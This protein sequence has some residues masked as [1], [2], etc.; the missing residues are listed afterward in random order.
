MLGTFPE[1]LPVKLR[2]AGWGLVAATLAVTG[3]H[4]MAPEAPVDDPVR[5]VADGDLGRWSVLKTADDTWTV[6]WRSPSRLP[7]TG[8][9]PRIVAG[10]EPVGTPAEDT[11]PRTVV[12]VVYAETAPDPAALDVVLSGDRLDEPGSDL[13]RRAVGAGE[14]APRPAAEAAP[15]DPGVP[16]N[17]PITTS[18]YTLPG[19]QLGGMPEKVEMVGHV[20]KPAASAAS[21]DHPL[22]LFLHG[23]HEFCYQPKGGATEGGGGDGWPCENGL[24]PIPSQL[25]YDYAQRLLASQGYVTVSIAANGINAQDYRLADGGAQ[26]RATLVRRHLDQWAKWAGSTHKVDLSKVILVGH[27]RGGEGVARAAL[28]IP[29]SA[30]YRIAGQVLLAPTDFSRQTSPYVPTATVLPYCDGD[31]SDLQGQFFTDRARDLDSR[32]TSLKSSVMV[33]GANHNFFNT[34]WTPGISAAPSFDDW[35]GPPTARCGRKHP[36]RLSAAEQRAVGKSYIAGA[37]RLMTK[38]DESVLPLYDGSPVRVPSAG[39][40]DVRTHAIG[41]GRRLVRPGGSVGLTEPVSADTGI[42]SGVADFPGSL[43]ICGRL[44]SFG[45][46][47]WPFRVEGVPAQNAFEMSWKRSGARGGLA[48]TN[49]LDLSAS[50]QLDLRTVVDP[51]FGNVR[52]RVRLHDTAGKTALVTPASG[53]VVPAMPRDDGLIPKLWAQTVRVDTAGVTGIDLAHIDRIELVGDSTDGRIWVLDAAAAPA[54]LPAVPELR[55]PV[56]E[57]GSATVTEG[58]GISIAVAKIPFTVRGTVTKPAKFVVVGVDYSGRGTKMQRMVVDIA[59]GQRSGFVRWGY[60]PN[61]IDDLPVRPLLLTAFGLSGSM[62]SDYLGSFKITDDDPAPKVTATAPKQVREGGSVNVKVKLSRVA[63]YDMVVRIVPVAGRVS[64]PRARYHDLPKSF[65]ERVMYPPPNPEVRLHKKPFTMVDF[66]MAGRSEI[67]MR[68]P[69]ARDG[70]REGREAMTLKIIAGN[71]VIGTRTV[72][73]E[74]SR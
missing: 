60:L 25:G 67:T 11:N 24:K 45:T 35:F 70:R 14:A 8:D 9:R 68:I 32:D 44:P 16:G 31:V 38:G 59:P 19:I 72:F 57:L 73:I 15:V 17:L 43:R 20:V 58:N 63:G 27:S 66:V 41:A 2:V 65:I 12:A 33:M 69:I 28:T 23:R 7:V 26:A 48:L 37:V 64:V 3:A 40:A 4:G 10:A 55:A 61:R 54:Q 13:A 36:D 47:H 51:T 34:E 6:T 71:K 29:L 39:N 42:C 52:L 1:R 30:P 18:N 56:V 62:P 74:P 5:Q 53:A 22:V 49:P 46:P 21:D 50:P